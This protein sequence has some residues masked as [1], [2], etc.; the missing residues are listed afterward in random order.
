[1]GTRITQRCSVNDQ[2]AF[3]AAVDDVLIRHQR[4]DWDD[5]E[6]DE[7]QTYPVSMVFLNGDIV[8]RIDLADVDVVV[9]ELLKLSLGGIR[10][11]LSVC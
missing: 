2:R 5:N 10:L 8:G 1:M 4:R 7:G 9:A 3:R 6:A 11:C